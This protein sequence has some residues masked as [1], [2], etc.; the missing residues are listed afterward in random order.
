MSSGVSPSPQHPEK[1]EKPR[2]VVD[3]Q[4]GRAFEAHPEQAQDRRLAIFSIIYLLV[5]M[6]F[7]FW[8]AFDVWIEAYRIPR[9]MGYAT[10]P[11]ST[12]T[13]LMFAFAFLG[14]A[15]GGIVDGLRSIIGWHS[16]HKAFGG[17]FVW[18]Y[19]AAPWLGAALAVFVIALVQSGVGLLGGDVASGDI[20]L[21]EKLITFALGVLAGYGSQTVIK[22]L[23][24]RVS[25]LFAV[26]R[27]TV[28]APVLLGRTL[29]EAKE[30]A[31]Q[32]QL[33]LGKVDEVEATGASQ[34]GKIIA[35]LPPAGSEVARGSSI[36]MTVAKHE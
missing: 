35:Q 19:I 18:K 24:A 4:T 25:Q 17:R 3:P 6:V 33:A 14:G 36:S 23:D 12:P 16:V 11:L 10:A 30:I 21:K 32:A 9:A 31:R 15:L 8:L 1:G 22:W 34:M 20:D 29:D 7:V 28:I 26:K 13:F 27:R 2:F 5:A